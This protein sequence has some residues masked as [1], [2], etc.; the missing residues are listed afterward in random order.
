MVG[1]YQD[2]FLQF[3]RDRLGE[4]IKISSTNII[5]RCPWCEYGRQKKHYHMYI[6][7]EAPIFHCFHGACNVSGLIPKLVMKIEGKDLSDQFVDEGE[8][9]KKEKARTKLVRQQIIPAKKLKRPELDEGRFKSKALYVK[10]RLKFRNVRLE[11]IKGLVFD[12]NNFIDI[13]EIPV[14]PSLFRLRDYLQENFVCFIAENQTRLYFRNIDEKQE[15]NHW[16][17]S[18]YETKFLDYYKL[19]G[20]SP[21]GK[22][23]VL[24]EGIFNIFTEHIFDSTNIK[25]DTRLYA[26]GFSTSYASLIVSIMKNERV[27]YPDVYILSDKD[28]TLDFYKNMSNSV[29][30][31]INSLTVVYNGIKKDRKD[32][33]MTPLY[34]QFEV[35][36]IDR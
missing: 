26:C 17:Y 3:L 24:S 5:C 31:Y 15:F 35:I 1:I 23:V 34:P 21:F 4:P 11:A 9:K 10:Q 8:M 12:I 13:N 2:S 14:S 36:G 6:S 27:L 29:G 22:T 33:N 7:L 16:K 25:K 28:I 19:K 32:F 30:R 18:L 20:G